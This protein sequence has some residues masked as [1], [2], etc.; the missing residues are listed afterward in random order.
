ME[1]LPPSYNLISKTKKDL[2]CIKEKNN[3]NNEQVHVSPIKNETEIAVPP[4][5]YNSVIIDLSR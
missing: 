4:P 1:E 2:Q 5:S 3:N